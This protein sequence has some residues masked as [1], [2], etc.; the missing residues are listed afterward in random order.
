MARPRLPKQ[1]KIVEKKLG[2][3]GVWGWAERE[4]DVGIVALDPRMDSKR[5]LEVLIHEIL[6]TFDMEDSESRVDKSARIL[7]RELWKKGFR[8]LAK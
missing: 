8:R 3:E 5:Y 4:G 2:K 7:A 6:H 1:I